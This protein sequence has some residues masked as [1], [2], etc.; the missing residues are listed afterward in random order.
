MPLR[1]ALAAS[2]P[3]GGCRVPMA[4]GPTGFVRRGLLM[5]LGPLASSFLWYRCDLLQPRYRHSERLFLIFPFLPVAWARIAVNSPGPST[6]QPIW[7]HGR[8]WQ[9]HSQL[10]E[11]AAGTL[12]VDFGGGVA[13]RSGCE[14]PPTLCPLNLE[15][16]W[17]TR[18]PAA[19]SLAVLGKRSPAGMSAWQFLLPGPHCSRLWRP[20]PS[21]CS[22]FR[23]GSHVRLSV[24]RVACSA[25]DGS[26]RNA[27]FE[28]RKRFLEGPL[29][30]WELDRKNIHPCTC[31]ICQPV[32][33]FFVKNRIQGQKQARIMYGCK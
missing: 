13:S 18:A 8:P 5:R 25:Q 21:W 7:L 15:L 10:L 26:Q 1:P 24:G 14:K 17:V 9:R 6:R 19:W 11:D 31:R 29:E 22:G 30:R 12:G 20:R 4:R 16:R 33:I 2:H 27:G 32:S 3:A 28:A 23:P